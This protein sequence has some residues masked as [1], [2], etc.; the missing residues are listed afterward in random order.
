[1]TTG[2]GS[3]PFT[4]PQASVRFV[5]E[6]GIDIPFWPQLPKRDFRELMNPQFAEGLPCFRTDATAKRTWFEIGD[7]K[8]DRMTAFYEKVLAGDYAGLELSREAAAG[9][10][11]FLAE[12]DSCK[13]HFHWLKGQVTGPLTFTLSMQDQD[14]RAI[15]YDPDLQEAS[16]Q[17][18]I[19][20]GRQQV[21][22]LSPFAERVLMFIDEPVLAA[23]G[24][25]AYLSL[26]D[27]DVVRLIDSVAE[28][29][30]EA[31]A[32]VG[33]HCC[34]N[35]DWGMMTRTQADI[36]SFDAYYYGDSVELYPNDIKRFLDGGSALAWGIVPTK[37]DVRAETA[38]T[39]L[40]RLERLMHDLASRGIDLEQLKARA[41]V[42]PSCG[43]GP[44]QEDDARRVFE[45]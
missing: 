26:K 34:G 33:V 7:D 10:H 8:S 12:L 29:L 23:F 13:P 22:A 1:M 19:V 36:L 42:T 32:L 40:G 44:M 39:L 41:L 11:A 27:E 17:A 21:E 3:V 28:P 6:S 38:D 24:T 43:T 2:I 9:Y 5:L 37:E 15:Y 18:L 31:G 14:R 16:V 45:L 20:K 25:S 30:K 35:T 4:D